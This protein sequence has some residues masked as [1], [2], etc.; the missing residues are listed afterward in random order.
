M[1]KINWVFF[2]TDRFSVYVLETL[3]SSG[4]LPNLI[5]TAEDKPKG[6]KLQLTPP[7]VKVWAE[8]N[9]ITL[10]QVK[11]LKGEEFLEKINTYGQFD[12]FLVASFGKIIP[13]DILNLP[14]SGTL[15]I[16]PSL[17]PKLRG[18]SPLE[19]AIIQENKT[20]VTII[21]LDSEID[22]GPIITQGEIIEWSDDNPP[23][24]EELEKKLAEEGARLVAQ[25]LP[26]WIQS[27][28]NALDQNHQ[29]ATFTEKIKKEDG[30]IS[31]DGNPIENLKKIRAYH[32]WPTCYFLS[33]TEPKKRV[34]V[35]KAKIENSL[36]VLERVTPEGKK[37]MDYSEYLKGNK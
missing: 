3:K 28:I 21:R 37:E 31:L 2:G 12:V 36:L 33:S 4:L 34:I 20:G 24:Y 18:P 1:N 22:H 26:D 5:V 7:E 30:L 10:I 14:K 6:R 8:E 27:K 16:H 9:N 15:N 32:F 17:L 23:Y 11:S 13:N 25:I 35:K 29:D 19:S